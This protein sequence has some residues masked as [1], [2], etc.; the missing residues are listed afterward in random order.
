MALHLA[1]GGL[2][3]ALGR[4]DLCDLKTR[5]LVDEP[6]DRI[7]C[8]QELRHVAAMEHEH[9]ELFALRSGL[10]D[11]RGD[12]LVQ[13]K[14]RRALRDILQ[15]IGIVVL[16]VDEDDLFGAADDVKRRLVNHAQIAGVEPAVRV[17]SRRGG[18]GIAEV[19]AGDA[20]AADQNV[21]DGLVRQ[22]GARIIRDEQFGVGHDVPTLTTSSASRA[23]MGLSSIFAAHAQ[24]V[25]VQANPA[26]FGSLEAE[27]SRRDE[28]SA[29]PYTGY[30]AL[31]FKPVYASAFMNSL[32]SA[33]EI[34][35]APL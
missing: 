31:R 14:T 1:A 30:M 26:K 28:P 35:S 27:R 3:D 23:S 9:H 13:I 19:A 10:R 17:D 18:P 5:V 2:G 22:A 15:I 8:G 4:N 21:P 24:A 20:G 33:A 29:S 6:A 11:S 7:R 16:T 34:G 25:A 12:N 32:Q